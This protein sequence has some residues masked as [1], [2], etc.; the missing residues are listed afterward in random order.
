VITV[1]RG[2]KM[3]CSAVVRRRKTG[4]GR[5]GK[6]E[7]FAFCLLKGEEKKGGESSGFAAQEGDRAQERYYRGK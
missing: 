1:L 6:E 2:K 7:S 5:K 4:P 3:D